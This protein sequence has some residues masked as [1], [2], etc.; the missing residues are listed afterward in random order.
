L[1]EVKEKSEGRGISMTIG[2]A[3]IRDWKGIREKERK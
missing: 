1:T 2:R 3:N